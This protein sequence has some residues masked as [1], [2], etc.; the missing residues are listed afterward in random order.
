[1]AQAGI[2][3]T[4]F[5]VSASAESAELLVLEGRVDFLD[6]QQISTAVETAKKASTRKGVPAKL[7]NMITSE[8]AEVKKAVEQAKGASGSI[9]LNRL[10]NT[11]DG[12]TPKSNYLVKSALNMELLWCPPGSFIM[13]P[14][15]EDSPAHPVI[16]TKKGFISENMKLPRSSTKK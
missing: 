12:Y 11:V 2:R 13:G 1:M 15:G 16:L 4:Q 8:Q 10:A 3:G 14:G 5:K 7:E 6:A 9:D